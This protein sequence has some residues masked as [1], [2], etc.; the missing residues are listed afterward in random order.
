MKRTDVAPQDLVKSPSR[1]IQMH[2]KGNTNQQAP[3]P[4]IDTKQ[5]PIFEV[6]VYIILT[7]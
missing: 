1:E 3:S 7:F 2:K 5:K 4:G 6:L